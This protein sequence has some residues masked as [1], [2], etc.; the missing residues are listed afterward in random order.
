[1]QAVATASDGSGIK[2]EVIITITNQVY[3]VESITINAPSGAVI[4]KDD[5]TLQLSAIVL[6]SD[7]TNNNISWS[8]IE[9]TGKATINAN[10][11]LQAVKNGTIKAIATSTD[12]S[13]V[14]AELTVTISNQIYPVESISISSPS[15]NFIN[16][17]KGTLKLDVEIFPADAT[18]KTVNWTVTDITGKATISSTGLLTADENGTVKVMASSTDGSGIIG[19]VLIT[20]SNQLVLVNTIAIVD[21][22]E[23]DTINGIGTKLALKPEVLPQNATNRSVMWE[24]ENISGQATITQ[25]GELTTISK[26]KIKV[27]VKALDESGLS[28]QKEYVIAI[29]VS[30]NQLSYLNNVKVFPNPALGRIHVQFERQ[31]DNNVFLEIRNPLGQ[32]LIQKQITKTKSEYDLAPVPF[33]FYLI[34]LTDKNKKITHKIINGLYA[35]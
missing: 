20:I 3:P 21:N 34:T 26:G 29:P 30:T 6:P 14:K 7:A 4:D 16:T 33:G 10:G 25:N 35:K 18:N 8:V 11:L 1:V 28:A 23:K 15:G 19:E 5:G 13:G 31:P 24:V 12:G 2:S 27:K 9:Q 22:L 17:N 32:L